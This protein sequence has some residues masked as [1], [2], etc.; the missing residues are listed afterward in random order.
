MIQ[1]L[2]ILG[3]PRQKGN[4]HAIMEQILKGITSIQGD[5]EVKEISLDKTKILPCIACDGCQRKLGCVLDDQMNELYVMFD[6]ADIVLAGSPI[7]FNAISA[8]LKAMIDRCQAIWSSKYILK[9]SLIDRDKFRLGLFVATAG[10]PE[11]IAEFMPSERIMDLFFKAIN[12][13][14]YH[15]F[16]I[17]NTDKEPVISRPEIFNQAEQLGRQMITDWI[18]EASK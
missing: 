11:G 13:E 12:T 7:Y 16:F 5:I 8:Q 15:N 14:Y 10:N 9:T 3:S 18:K 1:V 4:T 2:T 6:Q 17:T